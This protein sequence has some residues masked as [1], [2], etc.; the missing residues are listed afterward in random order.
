MTFI[1]ARRAIWIAVLSLAPAFHAQ[2][3]TANPLH[4][5]LDQKYATIQF[6]TGGLISTQGYFRR[7]KGDLAIDP[8]SPKNTAIN[9]TV[10][11]SAIQMPF[12]EGI[13]MLKSSAYL[14]ASKFPEITFRSISVRPESPNHYQIYGMLTIRGIM[15]TQIMDATLIGAPLGSKASA[16]ADFIVT[17]N[18]NRSDFGMVADRSMIADDISLTIHARIR[19]KPTASS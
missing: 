19:L 9:I 18:L 10:D 6:T 7:F 5:I 11:D 1:S 12:A 13:S 17:G 14:N 8:N 3:A 16:V 4:Y 2:S 15:R